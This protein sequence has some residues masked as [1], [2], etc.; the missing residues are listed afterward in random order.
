VTTRTATTH[1]FYI[2]V[3]DE[4]PLLQEYL[5]NSDDTPIDLTN[6]TSIK[7]WVW[8]FDS[9]V[10]TLIVDG[11]VGT[12]LDKP[13]GL[14]QFAFTASHTATRGEY[15]RR[16]KAEFPGPKLVSVPNDRTHGYPVVI[17]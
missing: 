4:L 16:W 9:G 2:G 10:Q 17:S 13:A 12:F 8:I 3:D 5:L 15:Q 7:L 14:V 1:T 6:A 11:E